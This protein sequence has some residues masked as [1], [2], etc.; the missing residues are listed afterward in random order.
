MQIKIRFEDRTSNHKDGRGKKAAMLYWRE[1]ADVANN[2][3]EWQFFRCVEILPANRCTDTRKALLE[4]AV[5]DGIELNMMWVR[6]RV[7]TCQIF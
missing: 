5:R 6:R 3:N 7:D 4:R 2:T 1:G